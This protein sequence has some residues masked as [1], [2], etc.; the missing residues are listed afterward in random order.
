MKKLL[1][2]ATTLI[3]CMI[4]CFFIV[5]TVQSQT[6]EEQHMDQKFYDEMES[7]YLK[8]MRQLL[9]EHDCIDS[10]ITMTKVMEADGT[11]DYQVL[12]HNKR[13]DRMDEGAKEALKEALASIPFTDNQCGFEIIFLSYEEA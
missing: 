1:F 12:I 11:R 4:S 8:E 13:I 10:G 3:L 5:G 6:K 9:K 2:I 7:T